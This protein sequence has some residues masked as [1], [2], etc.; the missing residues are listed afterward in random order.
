[1]DRLLRD[2]ATSAVFASLVGAVLWPPGRVYWTSVA[3]VVGEAATLVVVATA[4]L[5]FG[6]AFAWRTGL[7]TVRFAVGC[8]AAYAVGMA[9]VEA[10][11]APDG[12]AHLVWYAGLGTCLVVGVAVGGRLSS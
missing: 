5:G 7:S 11:V 3:A 1:M 8:L 10:A 6:V 12:P 4:A 2:A 9:A